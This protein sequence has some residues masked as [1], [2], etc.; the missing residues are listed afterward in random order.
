MSP[1]PFST[2]L[3]L[4]T[5]SLSLLMF[6]GCFVARG[7]NSWKAG[8]AEQRYER[9]VGRSISQLQSQLEGRQDAPDL[10]VELGKLFLESGQLLP[11][12][13]QVQLALQQECKLVS[14]WVLRGDIEMAKLKY[15]EALASYQH[16]ISLDKENPRLLESVAQCYLKQGRSIRAAA[17]LETLMQDFQDEP[18]PVGILS[19]YGTVMR[20]V[21]QFSQ[22]VAAFTQVCQRQNAD[23]DSFLQ[24]SEVQSLAGEDQASVETLRLG[25]QRFPNSSLMHQQIQR[26]TSQDDSLAIR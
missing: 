26:L 9:E 1:S 18:P 22:A 2:K 24:L 6:N 19:L 17:T 16:A 21:G 8:A 13:R 12:M 5:A 4:A 10:N 15:S 11:A 23:V 14:A 25:L 7:L 20:D 3:L